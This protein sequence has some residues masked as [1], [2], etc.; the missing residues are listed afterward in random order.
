[1]SANSEAVRT[2]NRQ[3][4]ASLTGRQ[5]PLGYRGNSPA[6]LRTEA[7]GNEGTAALRARVI[8]NVSV[9]ERAVSNGNK[10]G[11]DDLVNRR[12]AP[13]RVPNNGRRRRNVHLGGEGSNGFN[14]GSNDPSAQFENIQNAYSSLDRLTSAVAASFEPQQP[15]RRLIDVAVEFDKIC[16]LRDEASSDM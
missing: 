14:A 10:E 1:M 16:K 3:T 4:V 5:A 8:G 6:E 15:Q 9:G 2:E 13:V 7:T 12:S 11:V